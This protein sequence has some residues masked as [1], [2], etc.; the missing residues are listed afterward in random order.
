MNNTDTM[1]NAQKRG[2]RGQEGTHGGWEA[3]LG[4]GVRRGSWRK[5]FMT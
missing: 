4:W 1:V 3:D 5:G 2:T